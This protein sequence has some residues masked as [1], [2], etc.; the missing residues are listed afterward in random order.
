MAYICGTYD[1]VKKNISNLTFVVL[2]TEELKDD[3]RPGATVFIRQKEYVLANR[4][5]IAAGTVVQY[6]LVPKG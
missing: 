2:V 4:R 6:D 1:R 3:Y 5:F